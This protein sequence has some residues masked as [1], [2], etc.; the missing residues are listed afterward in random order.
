MRSGER[1]QGLGA[2]QEPSE[3]SYYLAS[4]HRREALLEAEPLAHHFDSLAS[5]QSC[6]GWGCVRA[7]VT[8]HQRR[9]RRARQNCG[10]I[11]VR[12]VANAGHRVH[13]AGDAPPTL[14]ILLLGPQDVFR[15]IAGDFGSRDR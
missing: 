6:G 13:D 12:V 8:R 2:P 4:G 7:E 5:L 15:V 11:I 14:L 3:N 9:T 10:A 1:E